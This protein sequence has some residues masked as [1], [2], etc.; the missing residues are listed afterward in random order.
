MKT[1]EIIVSYCN[2]SIQQH[3]KRDSMDSSIFETFDSRNVDSK[4]L[5]RVNSQDSIRA[6]KNPKKKKLKREI[7]QMK[8]ELSKYP[9]AFLKINSIRNEMTLKKK[10]LGD[11]MLSNYKLH[12]KDKVDIKMIKRK[13]KQ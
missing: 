5:S 3:R 10:E 2:T 7:K 13:V 12:G 8:S 11:L 4:N 6:E 9:K 1:L